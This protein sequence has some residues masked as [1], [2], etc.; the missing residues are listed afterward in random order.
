MSA[1]NTDRILVGKVV[2]FF[3]LQGWVKILS[4]TDPKENIFSYQHWWLKSSK[5]GNIEWQ[6]IDVLKGKSQ[7]KGLVACFA[8]IA[9]RTQAEKLIGLEIYID[10]SQMQEL[11]EDEFY[12]HEL[13]G[14]YVINQQGIEIGQVS[15]L[16][17]TGANDVLVIKQA[18]QTEK[19]AQKDLLIPYIWEQVI[20][21][22]DL[23]KKQIIVDW[24]E[25]YLKE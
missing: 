4:H 15:N 7:G 12:W 19:K 23:D 9:D 13:I 18:G 11:S 1:A 17:E 21:T 25:N 8:E 14:L 3:G 10:K 16:M 24:N 2:G 22:V 6:K 5:P 20:K